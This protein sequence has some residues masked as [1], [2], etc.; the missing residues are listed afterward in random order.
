MKE[1]SKNE[2][3]NDI[4]KKENL[5]QERKIHIEKGRRYLKN[6]RQYVSTTFSTTTKNNR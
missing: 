4:L 2:V 1:M 3:E 6:S 5:M